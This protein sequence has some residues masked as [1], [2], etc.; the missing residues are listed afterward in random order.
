MFAG[1]GDAFRTN[2]RFKL[3]S[4]GMAA[5]RLSTAVFEYA[6][7]GNDPHRAARHHVRLA[8]GR[9]DSIATWTT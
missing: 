6:G 2:T 1:E 4:E 8:I 7:N 3:L 5:K 9:A